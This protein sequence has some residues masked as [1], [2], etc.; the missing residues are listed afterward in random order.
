MDPINTA[1]HPATR[2]T[3][4]GQWSAGAPSEIAYPASSGQEDQNLRRRV[5]EFVGDI[6]YGTLIRQ[7]YASKLKGTHFHGGRGE[8]VFQGQLGMELARRMGRAAND[9]IANRLYESLRRN[10]GQQRTSPE[11]RDAEDP[12]PSDEMIDRVGSGT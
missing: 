8:E 1:N 7:M 3:T 12:G 5:G 4:I 10:T 11:P 6:F 9:P 2:L